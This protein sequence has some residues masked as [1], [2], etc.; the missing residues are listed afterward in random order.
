VVNYQT[1]YGELPP[2][3]ASGGSFS[4]GLR[5][6]GEQ[7]PELELT[8]PSHIVNASK[9]EAFM[10]SNKELVAEIKKLNAKVDK[11]EAG[12]YQIVKN[13]LKTAKTLEKFDYDGTPIKAWNDTPI[14]IVM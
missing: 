6:V 2:G 4:G 5:I 8:G 14:T 7:G 10:S 9:T 1:Q 11:L 3:F 13:T 12:N